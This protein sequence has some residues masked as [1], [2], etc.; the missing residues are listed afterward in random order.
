[1][2][3]P[4]VAGAAVMANTS[5]TRVTAILEAATQDATPRHSGKRRFWTLPL[6]QFL[7][8]E[9]IYTVELIAAPGPN[10]GARS[11]LVKALKGEPPF[12]DDGDYARMPMDLDPVAPED[13]AY[14]ENWIDEGCPP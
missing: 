7:A 12:G 11:G 8:I 2:P 3:D 5:Y 10:R 9:K 13:I 4:N 1:M 6:D 14:I